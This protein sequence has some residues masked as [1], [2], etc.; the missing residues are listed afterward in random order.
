MTNTVPGG[1]DLDAVPVTAPRRRRRSRWVSGTGLAAIIGSTLLLV[2]AVIG[3]DVWT[4]PAT[5]RNIAE[6]WATAGPEHLF[7]T[8]DIGRDIF[9]RVMVATRL[10]L[11]LTAGATAILIGGGLVIGLTAAILPRRARRG[12]IWVMDILLAFPW[13]LL[14][15]FFSVIWNVSAVGAMLAIGLAGIPSITRLVYNMASS[16]SDQDYVR[17]ARVIG[18][19]P[20]GVMVRHILPNI[21]NPLLVQSAAAA[22]TTLLSFAGLSFLGLGV[23]PPEYDWGRLL[24]EGL[25]HLY[26]NPMAAIGPGIAVVFAALVF[27]M[28]AE[29]VGEQPGQGLRAFAKASRTAALGRRDARRTGGSA[30]RS[31]TTPRS[32]ERTVGVLAEVRDLRVAFPDGDG[33]MIERVHGVS[34]RIMPG[35]IVGIVG[36]SGSGKSLTAMALAGLLERPA[37]ITSKRRVFDGIDLDGRLGASERRRLGVEIGVVFQDPLTSLNPALTIGRQLTE[38]PRHHLGLGRTAARR[39]AVDGLEAVGIP[40]AAGRLRDYPHQF[41]GGMRQRAMIGM[42]LTGT[43]RLIVADEPTTALDVTVQRQVLA[44]LRRAQRATGAGI[45]FIS[46]DIALVSGFCDRVVVMRDGAIVEELPAARIREDARHPYT[47]GLIACLPDM[48]TDRTQPLPVIGVAVDAPDGT[49]IADDPADGALSP[50]E[51]AR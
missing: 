23:Q 7:G 22:S 16:V 48:R 51:V 14:V 35:E 11:L 43:P 40:D 46:H 28:I 38:V 50:V 36:E 18:V 32:T 5:A 47:K 13:L 29:T 10:S 6:R 15:L 1:I 17:A 21:A 41:S 12:L 45:V 42:A 24:D 27:T 19:G 37:V 9:A 30:D 39:R 3:P 2:I 25:A 26:T 44:V 31:A 4:E 8:D 33:G 34:L 49:A 20:L